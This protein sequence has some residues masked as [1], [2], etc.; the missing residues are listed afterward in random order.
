MI[1]IEAP[2]RSYRN[3]S[4]HDSISNNHHHESVSESRHNGWGEEDR[5][6]GILVADGDVINRTRPVVNRQAARNSPNE[7]I[8]S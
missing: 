4:D 8:T 7:E 2:I 3:R 6:F 5:L 1:W